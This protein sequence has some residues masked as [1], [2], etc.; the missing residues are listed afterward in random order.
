MDQLEEHLFM[1]LGRENVEGL[2]GWSSSVARDGWEQENFYCGQV[3][4]NFSLKNQEFSLILH[5]SKIA[6]LEVGRAH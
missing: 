1:K 4:F 6:E 2:R 3:Y 5:N